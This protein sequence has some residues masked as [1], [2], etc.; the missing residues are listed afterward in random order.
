M[1]VAA[2]AFAER[3]TAARTAPPAAPIRRRRVGLRPFGAG[4]LVGLAL[5]GL[6]LLV[7]VAGPLL[8]PVDPERQNLVARLAPP[9]WAGGALDHPFG[10]DPLGRDLLAR[11]VAGARVS[12]LVGVV[13]TV[14]AGAA[15]VAL[16]LLAGFVGG[17]VDRVV[18]WVADVLLA[19]PFV[20]VAIAVTASIGSGLGPVLLT[21]A[22]T[23]WIGYARV[24][25]L[26]ARSLRRAPW[27]EAA[28]AVGASPGRI[29]ARHLLPNLAAP[30]LVLASQQ[31]AAMILYEAALSYLG[32]GIGGDA[33]TWGGMVADGR[34][35]LLVAPW[36]SVIPG[37]AIAAAVLGL[38]LLGD[39]LVERG[40]SG[41]AGR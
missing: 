35:T 21:L 16:G 36:V 32:L 40:R 12:L 3:G 7:A 31:V 5:S 23:G 39:A 11:V 10:T 37:S 22:A 34:E 38:N 18:T 24:V 26:Q 27:V 19:T 25:R 4:G 1:S 41:G 29:A 17:R 33:I 13:A 9:V 14:A 8:V 30:I 20:V 6:L 28:R 2:R 15:G